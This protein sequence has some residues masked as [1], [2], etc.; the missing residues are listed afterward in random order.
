MKTIKILN[1]KDIQNAVKVYVNGLH[2]GAVV[3]KVTLKTHDH[4]DGAPSI[5][6]EVE[7]EED[8]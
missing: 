2:D 7:I 5:S 1:E 8:E 3:K 6:A 4:G